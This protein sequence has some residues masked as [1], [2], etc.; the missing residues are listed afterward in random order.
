MAS[1]NKPNQSTLLTDLT[2]YIYGTTRLG[3]NK[4]PF[5]ERVKMA[6]TAI[7]TGVWFHASN[8]Y[9]NAHQVLRAAFD[10]DRTKVPKLIVKLEG[11]SIGELRK[12]LHNNLELLGLENLEIGQ[13]CLGTGE[14]AR[15]FANGGECYWE[16][17]RI[18]AEGLVN[19]FVLEVFPWT[20]GTALQALK[21]GYPEGIVD[22]YIYYLN[23][24]QRFA[25]NELWELLNERKE[26]QIALR[27]VAGG[28]VHWLRDV[29]GAAWKEYLQK[30]AVEVAPIFERS[31]VENWT[32]FCVRFAFSFEN[33]R[34]TI[35]ATSHVENLNDF[36]SATKQIQPL[37]AGI[38]DEITRLQ[39][40]WSD[41]TDMHAEAWTM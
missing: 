40:R 6:H 5:A 18:K 39:C 23:P 33:I 31:G 26:A 8:Q 12:D 20:S 15:D 10:E 21:A 28:P 22:G 29:P 14:L 19:R 1:M 7:E 41:E 11:N 24:L 30:R 3:D 27:T 13:L 25:S 17:V 35:G 37:P 4:I 2:P 38:I 16:F 36:L 9:N 32:D 34:A